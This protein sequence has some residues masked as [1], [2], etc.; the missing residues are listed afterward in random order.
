VKFD[1]V[2]LFAPYATGLEQFAARHNL[3]VSKYKYDMPEWNFSFRHPLGGVGRIMIQINNNRDIGVLKDWTVDDNERLI[4]SS[5]SSPTVHIVNNSDT[6]EATLLEAI[7]DV[8]GWKLS[9]LVGRSSIAR[10]NFVEA[11]SYYPEV[12]L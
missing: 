8:L 4:R 3:M 2:E 6:L 1:C 5:K 7:K 12:K 9:E 10:G 11:T